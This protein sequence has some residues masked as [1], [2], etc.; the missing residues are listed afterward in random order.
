MCPTATFSLWCVSSLDEQGKLT[1]QATR[2]IFTQIIRALAY[3]HSK[4]IYHRDIKAENVLVDPISLQAKLTD[5][6]FSVIFTDDIAHERM[7]TVCGT[8]NYMAPEILENK[9]YYG[10]KADIWSAGVLLF[11]MT[12]GSC[13]TSLSFRRCQHG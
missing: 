12:T 4:M 11:V 9:G 5:F 10:P 1:E 2:T 6:G 13:L 7:H 3:C 8:I